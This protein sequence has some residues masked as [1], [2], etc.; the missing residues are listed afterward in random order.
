MYFDPPPVFARDLRVVPAS[1]VLFFF[2]WE[3]DGG[4]RGRTSFISRIISCWAVIWWEGEVSHDLS[5]LHL[6]FGHFRNDCLEVFQGDAAGYWVI[7]SG[8][9]N[10][11]VGNAMLSVV[12]VW[13]V[14]PVG[15][16]VSYGIHCRNWVFVFVVG[17]APVSGAF[18]CGACSCGCCI[19]SH[20][21]A[22]GG[23]G[24]IFSWR[25]R[26]L[27]LVLFTKL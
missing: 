2:L 7:I 21:R 23:A 8:V 11:V 24:F 20:G 4:L 18:L 9:H 6:G 10:L 16:A 22:W 14:I 5:G 17:V 15:W 13:R 25:G 1:P 26:N 3:I 27:F 12:E 19:H